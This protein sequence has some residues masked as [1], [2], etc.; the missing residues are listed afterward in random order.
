MSQLQN[1]RLARW[2]NV[3]GAVLIVAGTIGV[4]LSVAR[5]S[6][7]ASS[8]T[9][10]WGGGG[11]FTRVAQAGGLYFAMTVTPG[12][13]FLGELLQVDLSLTNSSL[14]TYTLG[15]PSVSGICGGAVYVNT[16]GGT[17]PFGGDIININNRNIQMVTAGVNYTFGAW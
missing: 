14:T 10:S 17:G 7:S 13:Y 12:P 3:L 8:G 1:K 4:S 11:P 2:L 15:G 5:S 9:A 16:V 6:R